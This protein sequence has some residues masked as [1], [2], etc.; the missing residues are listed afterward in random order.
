MTSIANIIVYSNT[1]LTYNGVCMATRSKT[2]CSSPSQSPPPVPVSSPIR[3]TY[4]CTHTLP[5][6]KGNPFMHNGCNTCHALR[7]MEFWKCRIGHPVPSSDWHYA[8]YFPLELLCCYVAVLTEKSC[9]SKGSRFV[10]SH[11]CFSYFS[12]PFYIFCAKQKPGKWV[13]LIK[14]VTDHV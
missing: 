6:F 7:T 8:C 12:I 14:T 11:I 4:T 9:G 2:V 10:S 3:T 5:V 13:E 1:G